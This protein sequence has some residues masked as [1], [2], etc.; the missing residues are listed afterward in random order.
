MIYLSAGKGASK[1]DLIRQPDRIG[2]CSRQFVPPGRSSCRHPISKSELFE[3]EGALVCHEHRALA[4]L[5]PH[6]LDWRATDLP[7]I[8]SYLAFQEKRKAR[9]ET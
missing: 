1:L 4:W 6:E 3:P 8:S 2:D 9:E 5:S 7:V